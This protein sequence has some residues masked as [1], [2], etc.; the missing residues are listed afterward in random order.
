[1]VSETTTGRGYELPHPTN[2]LADDVYRLRAGLGQVDVDVVAILAAL[3]GK[4]NAVH[5]HVIADI[6]G[7]S[8]ALAGKA[9]STHSHALGDLSNVSV[10]GAASGAVLKF[11]GSS[12]GAS[13]L[14]ISDIDGLSEALSSIASSIEALT[15]DGSY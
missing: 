4:A 8:A 1:M 2:R 10:T 6:D 15:D 3:A 13:R 12:W 7:L 5:I 9:S 14:S 11:S